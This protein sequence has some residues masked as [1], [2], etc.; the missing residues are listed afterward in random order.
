MPVRRFLFFT[1]HEIL[2]VYAFVSLT[3]II[4]GISLRV[5]READR[6]SPFP[7]L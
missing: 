3:W 7:R 2:R 4:M 5:S 1:T 6:L